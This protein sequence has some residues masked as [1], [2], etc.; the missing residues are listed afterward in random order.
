MLKCVIKGILEAL[1]I[2][3]IIGGIITIYLIGESNVKGRWADEVS[4]PKVVTTWENNNVTTWE[5]IE[6]R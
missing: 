6:V 1:L 3:G 2:V 4:H 5:N